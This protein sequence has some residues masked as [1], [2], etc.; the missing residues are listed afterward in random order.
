MERNEQRVDVIKQGGSRQYQAPVCHLGAR[1]SSRWWTV[2]LST[3]G[4]RQEMTKFLYFYV[5]V[6]KKDLRNFPFGENY[7]KA[8][9]VCHANRNE[10]I[11]T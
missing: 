4:Y 8:H 5:R 1:E 6:F 9:V 3:V 10:W 11:C 7:I 2:I